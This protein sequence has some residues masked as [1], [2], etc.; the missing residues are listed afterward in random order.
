MLTRFSA[1]YDREEMVS[2]YSLVLA[3]CYVLIKSHDMG[4][5]RSMRFPSVTWQ[6]AKMLMRGLKQK[7]STTVKEIVALQKTL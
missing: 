4:A 2:V 3:G 7:P 1:F 6:E 5:N